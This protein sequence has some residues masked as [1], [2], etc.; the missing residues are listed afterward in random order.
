MT[1][2][3]HINA[4]GRGKISRSRAT[5]ITFTETLAAKDAGSRVHTFDPFEPGLPGFGADY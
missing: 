5:A 4:R 1:T 2:L 3:L